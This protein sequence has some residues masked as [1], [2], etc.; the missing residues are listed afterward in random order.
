V[1][2]LATL[3]AAAAYV[4]L[5]ISE[6]TERLR[7]LIEDVGASVVITSPSQL[8]N[9][10]LPGIKHVVLDSETL[11]LEE[12]PFT[13]LPRHNAADDV[14]CI[15]YTSGSTGR[16]KAVLVPHR[17]VVRLVCGTSYVPFDNS[18]H[19]LLLASPAFDASTF[20]LWGAL[21]HGSTCVIYPRQRLSF[22]D[23]ELT[24]RN[25]RI[26]C[27]WLTASLF[28][29]VVDHRPEM[30]A[31]VSRLMIGG[32]GLSI[33]HVRRFRKQFPENVLINGYGPTESTTFTTTYTI[34]GQLDPD[35]SSI[36]IGRPIANTEVYVLDGQ[37]QPVPIGVPG[38]LFIGGAGLAKG[39]L[40]RPELTAEK[41]VANPFNSDPT[42]Q[43]YRTGDLVRWHTDGNLE[44]LGRLDDQVKIRG[45]RIEPGEIE[46][47]LAAQPGV[48]QAAVVCRNESPMGKHLAAYVVPARG[49]HVDVAIL[50]HALTARLPDYMVPAAFMIL[51]R[52]PVTPNGKLD[53][54]ALPA[55]DQSRSELSGTYSGPRNPIEQKLTTIWADVLKRDQ[56]GIYDNFFELGGHSLLAAVLLARMRTVLNAELTLRDLFLAPT[57]AEAVSL[58]KRALPIERDRQLSS[59][60]N[61]VPNVCKTVDRSSNF[62]QPEQRLDGGHDV[63]ES[64]PFLEVIRPGIAERAIVCVGDT[65]PIPMILARF[66]ERIPV[67]HLKL[68]GCHVW[69]P[70]YMTVD[71]Q[72]ERYVQSLERHYRQRALAIVGYS[73][74]GLLAYRLASALAARNWTNVKVLLVE[75]SV[76]TRYHPAAL[77]A[78][79][80]LRS[81]FPVR[82]TLDWLA[83]VPRELMR[84]K[85]R[86]GTPVGMEQSATID[87]WAVMSP[88]YF[89]NIKSAN[90]SA[91]G[92]P[93]SLV[94]SEKYHFRFTR[95]WQ[96]IA[97]GEIYA[98]VLPTAEGHLGIFQGPCAGQF[99]AFMERWYQA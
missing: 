6:P 62:A 2:V 47:A 20:E 95:R 50:R 85:T 49:A 29:A 59:R 84:R 79:A 8:F 92:R 36:P 24:L 96:K 46:T 42:A 4:P 7:L 87:R 55:P 13:N 93:V 27:L 99:A 83:R 88:Q 78:W 67:W 98:C 5:E 32:E 1:S 38:E 80:L 54:K 44:F 58:M 81:V 28:N 70:H 75:P 52:L 77:R 66:S 53:R 60:P 64:D 97:S 15:I 86:N 63:P 43:L 34:P 48:A 33:D 11:R 91:L 72:T 25:Q 23:L 35:L 57:I 73:Y 22:D 74:G 89:S 14:A 37:W 12:Q 18:Q 90:L 41:F 3:K 71:E 51:D 69:P 9:L 45:F 56:I 65:R 17:G 39:Y 40:N 82:A 26:T 31:G 16:P 76:P 61:P 19:F 30:L 21:L 10:N 94:A 68:D